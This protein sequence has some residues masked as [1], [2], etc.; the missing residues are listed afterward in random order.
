[1]GHEPGVSEV[2]VQA[3]RTRRQTELPRR[4]W[5]TD[6]PALGPFLS[7]LAKRGGIFASCCVYLGSG[8]SVLAAQMCRPSDLGKEQ[9]AE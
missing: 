4:R 5:R 2:E 6:G 1:M 9:E 3:G 8:R 7:L